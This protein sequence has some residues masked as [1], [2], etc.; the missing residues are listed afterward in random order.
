MITAQDVKTAAG[1]FRKLYHEAVLSGSY[2]ASANELEILTAL[3]DLDDLHKRMTESNRSD[4]LG[5][6]V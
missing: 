3:H 5:G 6:E 1:H 4:F 2:H